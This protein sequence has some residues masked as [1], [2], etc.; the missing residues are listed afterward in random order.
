MPEK[1]IDK[2]RWD[3]YTAYLDVVIIL[4]L[5]GCIYLIIGSSVQAGY[6]YSHYMET[7]DAEDLNMYMACIWGLI[8]TLALTALVLFWLFYRYFKLRAERR[9]TL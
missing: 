1:L 5:I 6:Y 4:V 3:K 8:G 2:R 9:V 7:N